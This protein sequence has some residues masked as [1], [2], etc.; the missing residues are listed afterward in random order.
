MSRVIQSIKTVGS[1]PRILLFGLISTA[2][3]GGGIATAVFAAKQ[4][5]LQSRGKGVMMALLLV[6][7]VLLA[8]VGVGLF[9]GG[10]IPNIAEKVKSGSADRFRTTMAK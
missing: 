5:T 1:W 6:L 4:D 3:I 2:L 9:I 8:A 10:F 7:G